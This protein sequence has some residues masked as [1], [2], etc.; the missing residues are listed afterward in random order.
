MSEPLRICS[1]FSGIGGFEFGIEQTPS[2]YIYKTVFASEIDAAASL[3]YETLH[4]LKPYGD[5]TKISEKDIPDHDILVGGFPCQA[6]SSAGRRMGFADAR[7]TLFFDIAR[8]AKEK[9]PKWMLLENVKGLLHHDS[10]RTIRTI[11]SVLSEIGYSVD[12]QLMNSKHYTPHN[13]ER[14]FILASLLSPNEKWHLQDNSKATSNVKK[15]ILLDMELKTFNFPFPVR[16]KIPY[17][18]KDILDKRADIKYFMNKDLWEKVSKH[19]ERQSEYKTDLHFVG[20]VTEK[21]NW[22]DNGKKLSRNYKQGSRIYSVT[23][24]A[25]TLTAQGVGGLGGHTGYYLMENGEI[26]KLTPAECFKLQGFKQEHHDLLKESGFSESQLYKL[27]GN[28]VTTHV[29]S[30]LF[31][32]ILTMFRCE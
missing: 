9:K 30:D 25:S 10:G 27:A 18:L 23:G 17:A 12:F 21:P 19:L 26:R 7:G 11:L 8:I 16:D 28:S 32:S 5:I 1:L 29:V 2:S 3:A 31:D 15:K 4:G 14:V 24:I 13:R 6:F 22:L 20:G